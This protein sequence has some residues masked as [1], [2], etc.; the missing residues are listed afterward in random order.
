MAGAIDSR[1]LVV[2]E[3]DLEFPKV[4]SRRVILLRS[5]KKSHNETP[6]L[7]PVCT[8]GSLNATLLIRV[9]EFYPKSLLLRIYRTHSA[10]SHSDPI[11]FLLMSQSR[12]HLSIL[13]P[14]TMGQGIISPIK[15]D[16]VATNIYWMEYS[17]GCSVDSVAFIISPL[18]T[19]YPRELFIFGPPCAVV[20]LWSWT[21][22]WIPVDATKSSRLGPTAR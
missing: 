14:S 3:V 16:V 9:R 18:L 6:R 19:Q 20:L 12:L 22:K 8:I 5:W 4:T 7:I 17:Y 13:Q 15:F 21:N 10:P 2:A 1:F 11:C